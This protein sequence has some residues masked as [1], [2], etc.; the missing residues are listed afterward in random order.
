MR[1]SRRKISAEHIEKLEGAGFEWKAPDPTYE[2]IYSARRQ[3]E[4]EKAWD[5]KFDMLLQFK[6]K[7]GHCDVPQ[8]SKFGDGKLGYWVNNQRQAK[9]GKRKRKISTEHKE[10]L[11]GA[12][13]WG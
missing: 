5:K 2:Q 4:D 10:K 12:G 6:Q 7:N 3:A 13:F 11:E 8:K 1:N 9:K